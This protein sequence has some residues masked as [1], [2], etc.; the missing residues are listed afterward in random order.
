MWI[1][2]KVKIVSWGNDFCPIYM[3]RNTRGKNQP[4]MKLT[5]YLKNFL[6]V[7]N[8][9]PKFKNRTNKMS[10]FNDALIQLSWIKRIS[11]GKKAG[12]S[13]LKYMVFINY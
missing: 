12:E 10:D 9:E 13:Y 2:K 3:S 4:Y 7:Q 5:L 6:N 11:M 1:V 8:I